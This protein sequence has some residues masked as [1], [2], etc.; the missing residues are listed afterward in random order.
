[1]E[2]GGGRELS[3]IVSASKEQGKEHLRCLFAKYL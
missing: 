2:V 3:A 1:M